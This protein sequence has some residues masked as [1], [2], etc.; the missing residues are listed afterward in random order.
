MTWI[1]LALVRIDLHTHSTASDGTDPPAE[2]MS[3]LSPRSA[4]TMAWARPTRAATI[5]AHSAASSAFPGS[6]P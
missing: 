4:S 5:A 1:A 6:T 3:T 2:V